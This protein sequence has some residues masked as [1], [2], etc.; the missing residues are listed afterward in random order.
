MSKN[1]RWA[2]AIVGVVIII[3][4]AIV[5]GTGKDNTDAV[6]PPSEQSTTETGATQSTGTTPATGS[7]GSGGGTTNGGSGTDDGSGS[8]G[9]SPSDSGENSGGSSPDI[10]NDDSSGGAKAKVGSN[11]VVSP[12]LSDVKVQ[13]VKVDKGEKVM[14]RGLSDS[15]GEM[16]VHGYDKE[17]PLKAGR[18]ARV[19]F[20]ANIDGEFAIEFHLSNGG[21]LDVG[22]LRVSP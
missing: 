16:H 17:V 5:I 19:T 12:I 6:Q 2:L 18:I 20:T 10:D 14:I 13:T 8:G 22:T 7:T 11:G 1:T 4:G 21:H 15:S 3:V 9:A